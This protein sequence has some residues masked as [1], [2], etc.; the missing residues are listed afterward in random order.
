MTIRRD[1]V[2]LQDQGVLIRTH[3][4][5]VMQPVV[6]RELTFAEKDRRQAAQKAAIARELTRHIRA[7][8]AVYLDTG[9]TAAQVARL[10]PSG[11]DL[12]VCTNNLAAAIELF[13]R[14]GVRVTVFGGAMAPKSPDLVGELALDRVRNFHFDVAVLGSDAF[15]PGR[16]EFYSADLP[17][18]R[19]SRAVQERAART[20]FAVDSSKFGRHG[21]HVAGRFG[22]TSTLITD[23]GVSRDHLRALE[24]H[25]DA[26]RDVIV[27]RAR[28]K[29]RA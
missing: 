7:G 24:L 23:D 28:G 19:L 21:P 1:L 8:S 2:A 4:G 10:L 18:A 5:C 16:G 29:T 25:R 14:E 13:S 26:G 20:L 11:L 15:D 27:A 6:V 22:E 3:G 17:T 12:E 9:T